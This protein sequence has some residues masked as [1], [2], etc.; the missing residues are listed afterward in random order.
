M[1]KKNSPPDPMASRSGPK[2][3]RDLACILAVLDHPPDRQSTISP[4]K[5]IRGCGRINRPPIESMY[6]FGAK[7]DKVSGALHRC[8]VRAR[9]RKVSRSIPPASLTGRE[10]CISM[11]CFDAKAARYCIAKQAWSDVGTAEGEC[12]NGPSRIEER[13]EAFWR[14][15]CPQ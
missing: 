11:R 2:Q 13:F 7:R 10:R 4:T 12:W 6:T 15:S 14:H 8:R 1:R 3:S 5:S 9:F